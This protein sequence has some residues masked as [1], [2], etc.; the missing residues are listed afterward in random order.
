LVV[1]LNAMVFGMPS[2]LFP[3]MGV[4]VFAGDATTVGLL[5]SAPGVGALIAALS[6]G[7]IKFVRRQGVAVVV[8]V[9]AWGVAIAAF[10]LTNSLALALLMLGVAGAADVVSAVFRNSIVQLTVPDALRG[11][12]SSIHIATVSSGP[13]LGDLEAGVVAAV[14]STQV[15]VVSGGLAC[16][17]GTLLIARRIPELPGFR[18][19]DSTRTQD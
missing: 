17:I 18:L 13:R 6:S 14:T 19:D 8:S 2:A 16:A 12:I 7:W 4:T 15:S 5:Y 1:D 9:T 10:G 3:E 11:R